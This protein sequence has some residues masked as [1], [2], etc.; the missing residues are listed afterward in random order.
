MRTEEL[1]SLESLYFFSFG[2]PSKLEVFGILNLSCCAP[3]IINK[4][5]VGKIEGMHRK[6]HEKKI[7]SKGVE[8]NDLVKFWLHTRN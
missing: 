2:Q 3:F 4:K 6:S 5:I 1:S 7:V 8:M